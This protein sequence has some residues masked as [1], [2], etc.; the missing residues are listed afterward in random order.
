M[1]HVGSWTLGLLDLHN[2]WVDQPTRKSKACWVVAEVLKKQTRRNCED[3]WQTVKKCFPVFQDFNK[4]VSAKVW[5]LAQTSLSA[6]TPVKVIRW[7]LVVSREVWCKH[8]NRVRQHC[9]NSFSSTSSCQLASGLLEVFWVSICLKWSAPSWKTSLSAAIC[10]VLCCACLTS[11]LWQ[12]K[13]PKKRRSQARDTEELA[14]SWSNELSQYHRDIP[15]KY[16]LSLYK[17]YMGLIIKGTIPRVPS[18]SLW[19]YLFRKKYVW[20]F[21]PPS[22]RALMISS[23]KNSQRL[24][25]ILTISRES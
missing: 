23:Q 11:P 6:K 5:K 15:N 21:R 18:F 2:T 7:S 8:S 10:A 22:W 12:T 13:W 19:Q 17:V 1:V 24:G 4:V 25:N 20:F 9:I 14:A 16:P 3:W